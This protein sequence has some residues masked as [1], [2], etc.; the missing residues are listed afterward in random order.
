MMPLTPP[1]LPSLRAIA[2]LR[3]DGDATLDR[4]IAGFRTSLVF[5][6]LAAFAGGFV[7]AMLL[8][9]GRTLGA[10]FRLSA[11]THPSVM[12]LND[13]EAAS[14]D[15]YAFRRRFRQQL[16]TPSEVTLQ[17]MEE[18]IRVAAAGDRSGRNIRVYIVEPRRVRLVY[19]GADKVPGGS[20]WAS[21]VIGEFDATDSSEAWITDPAWEAVH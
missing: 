7:L 15:M 8:C 4:T 9:N 2:I 20:G 3:S 6:V 18:A 13:F 16:G 17:N 12:A 21:D 14:A 19:F 10:A 1:P 5:T 11:V